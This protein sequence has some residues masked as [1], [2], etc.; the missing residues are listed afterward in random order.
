MRQCLTCSDMVVDRKMIDN[1]RLS[2]RLIFNFH[3][4]AR[5]SSHPR[6]IRQLA[7]QCQR[8]AAVLG[9]SRV[10]SGRGMDWQGTRSEKEKERYVSIF[11]NRRIDDHLY[12]R[13]LGIK[14]VGEVTEGF[15]K[16]TFAIASF[17]LRHRK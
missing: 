1:D 7:L 12:P 3:I 15:G 10:M 4:Q 9:R 17:G 2:V 13:Q 5:S 11:F 6:L 16:K 14:V 8:R